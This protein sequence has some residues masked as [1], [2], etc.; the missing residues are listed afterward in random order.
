MKLTSV[1]ISG[2]LM[3]EI[4]LP[5]P[6]KE[7]SPN[8]KPVRRM[9][10]WGPASRYRSKVG[11][12]TKG[13]MQ[14]QGLTTIKTPAQLSLS[15]HFRTRRRRDQD[16]VLAS[17]KSGIDGMVDGGLLV[18]DSIGHLSLTMRVLDGCDDEGVYVTWE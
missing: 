1:S 12:I 6:P 2:G 15:F 17:F 7:L 5:L 13:Q 18:D 9:A 14:D 8:Y 3:P 16:N 10:K 11:W 4:I